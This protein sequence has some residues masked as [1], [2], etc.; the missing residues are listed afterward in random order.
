[1]ST[2][3]WKLIAYVATA[4]VLLLAPRQAAR[5]QGTISG[6]VTTQATGQPLPEARVL[7]IGTSLSATSAED[8]RFTIRNAPNGIAQIQ[9]LRVGFQSQK[10]NVTVSPGSTVVADF[11]L[12][13]AVAQL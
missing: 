11:I 12:N 1:M 5:A 4:T 3:R 2:G 13:V 9:V 8:G 6:R 7:V 10:K